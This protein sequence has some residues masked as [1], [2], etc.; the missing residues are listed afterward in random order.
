MNK[1]SYESVRQIPG[2][3]T[4]DNAERKRLFVVAFGHDADIKFTT[5]AFRKSRVT[6]AYTCSPIEGSNELFEYRVAFSRCCA[7]DNFNRI[8]GQSRA[9]RR[10][11]HKHFLFF[12]SPKRDL[13][14][15]IQNIYSESHVEYHSPD[16]QQA[17]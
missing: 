6:A 7:G 10:L 3:N 12:V 5:F 13:N 4:L 15:T 1:H 8:E 9:M 2:F 17:I 16:F 11:R 14:Q